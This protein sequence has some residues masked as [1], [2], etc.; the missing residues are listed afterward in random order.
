MTVEY[1]KEGNKLL[2][3]WIDVAEKVE[4]KKEAPAAMEAKKVNPSEKAAGKE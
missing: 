1:Q 2:A 3:E 4:A